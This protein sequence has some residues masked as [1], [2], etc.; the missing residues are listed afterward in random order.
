MVRSVMPVPLGARCGPLVL[1][2][3]RTPA[4]RSI[5]CDISSIVGMLRRA[6]SVI[7]LPSGL[8]TTV[9]RGSA[10]RISTIACGGVR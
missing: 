1:G 4:S 7:V 9:G 5:G 6:M 3:I 10:S 2:L 8:T